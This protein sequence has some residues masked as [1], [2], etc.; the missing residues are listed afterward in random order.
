MS[1]EE[2]QGLATEAVRNT[3]IFKL[4][5][6]SEHGNKV[7]FDI[8]PTTKVSVNPDLL[9]TPLPYNPLTKQ[10]HCSRNNAPMSDM[11]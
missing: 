11:T 2:Q 5:T 6:D 3:S 7:S 8:S 9:N 4:D 1:N 10:T